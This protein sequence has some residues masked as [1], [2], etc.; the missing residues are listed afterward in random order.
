M[1]KTIC[2]TGGAGMI[3]SCLA[4]KL[5]SLGH[6]VI[7]IDNLW[8]GKLENISNIPNF[9]IERQFHNIDLSKY[10]NEKIVQNIF[11]KCD[12]LIHL[13]DI[14][15]GIDYVF[16]NEYDIFKVNNIINSNTFAWAA[17][18]NVNKVLYAGTA[19]S[20]PKDMQSGL[21]SVLKESD[22]FPAEP[23]SGY[24]WSKLV[25]SLELQYLSKK[26]DFQFSTLMLHNVYGIH[27]DLDPKKMQVI[28]SLI[29][30][31]IHLKNGEDL[32]VWGSGKQG[33]AFLYVED[34][35]D[36]F[37]KAIDAETLPP[38]VQIGP[39]YC[40]S[41]KEL[42]EE[43]IKI[44][45][46]DIKIKFDR[47]KPEGDKGRYANYQLAKETLNWKPNYTLNEGLRLTYEWI[48]NKLNEN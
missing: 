47:T 3:G 45:G 23:E 48:K 22:L 46:K 33:R 24:G 21:D 8:R 30:R 34:V 37:K 5:C 4:S 14:V 20:F 11:T 19:C 18:A 2:I 40:T 29:H 39:D 12:I 25:G 1:N 6:N 7:I 41:I 28:P 31:L 15:A 27:S 17:N 43:L 35:V 44:S 16:N 42:A 32:I 13:A 10:Q 26:V 36:A 38:I 9:D